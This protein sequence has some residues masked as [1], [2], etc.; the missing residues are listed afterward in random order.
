VITDRSTNQ[1]QI[2]KSKLAQF[3][4]TQRESFSSKQTTEVNLI[5]QRNCMGYG[6]I[7]ETVKSSR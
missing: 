5:K 2:H 3:I 6:F 4:D 7:P 1:T